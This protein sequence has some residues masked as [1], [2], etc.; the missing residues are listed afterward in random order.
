[1]L[2]LSK[3]ERYIICNQLEILEKLKPDDSDSYEEAKVIFQEGFKPHYEDHM[4]HIAGEVSENLCKEVI[5]TLDMHVALYRSKKALDGKFK[6]RDFL[7]RGY[8]FNNA[9]E[10]KM[11]GYAKWLTEKRDRFTQVLEGQS[12]DFKF[13]SHSSGTRGMYQAQLKKWEE[14]DKS[15]DLNESQLKEIDNAK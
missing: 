14:F 10:C 1:M 8:D 6:D 7:F 12:A 11:G 13:N 4:C 5:D 15:H 3:A 9:I 2:E